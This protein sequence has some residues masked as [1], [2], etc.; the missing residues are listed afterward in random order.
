MRWKLLVPLVLLVVIAG[1]GLY[2]YQELIGSQRSSEPYQMALEQAKKD[3]QVVERL[4]EPIN[5]TWRVGGEVFVEGDRGEAN[6]NFELVGPKGKASA[7]TQARRI[8]GKWG[9]TTLEVTF[10]DG[11]RISVETA[12][13]EGMEDA[14]AWPPK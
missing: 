11:Q 3:A 14:P 6:L 9:L 10:D 7:R 13:H 8:E 5:D 1:G 4:G 2:I 12:A